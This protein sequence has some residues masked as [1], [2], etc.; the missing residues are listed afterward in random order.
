MSKPLVV[1]IPHQLG[2]E[3][4]IRRLKNGLQWGREKY[5]SLVSIQQEDWSDDQ[6]TFRIGALGQSAN[7]AILVSDSDVTLTVQLPWLLAKFAEKA[8]AL[9]QKQGQLM[10]EKK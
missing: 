1:S 2:R 10:L 3:E 4:A 9:L 6:L 5:G 8:Q 7:G